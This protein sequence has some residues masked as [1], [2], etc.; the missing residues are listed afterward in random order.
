MGDKYYNRSFA[1]ISEYG[2]LAVE[3]LQRQLTQRGYKP[4]VHFE[5]EGGYIPQ[6]STHRTGHDTLDYDTINQALAGMSIQGR[7]KPEYWHYQWEYVSTFQGQ[8]PLKVAADLESVI[9][10]LP[11]LLKYNGAE[12]VFIKPVLWDGDRGRLAPGCDTIFS[13]ETKSVHVPNA[14][15]INISA[16]DANNENVIPNQGIG[17]SLQRCLLVTSYECSL[18][19]LPEQEAFDRLRLKE[20]FGLSRELCSPNDLSGGHQGSIALYK[21]KGKHNQ[22]MGDIPL[23]YDSKHSVIASRQ[24][25]RPLS[26]IEH[27]LGASSKLFNPYVNTAFALANLSDALTTSS[28]NVDQI[29]GRQLAG[30]KYDAKCGPDADS[31]PRQLPD[32]LYSCCDKLGAVELFECGVWLENKINQCVRDTRSN[33]IEPVPDDLG[34]LLKQAILSFYEKGVAIPRNSK[35][36][37][38]LRY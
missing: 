13:A 3:V 34:S 2:K 29:G 20:Q 38:P 27:R 18:L 22:L 17:E 14:I 19:Y 15:Q 32:S 9:K 36:W 31:K 16:V 26:R 28:K 35:L 12:E 1:L 11:A 7:L 10:I 5:L 24:E 30:S 25:W 33:K 37:A 4:H 8:S 6:S 23:L 21:E